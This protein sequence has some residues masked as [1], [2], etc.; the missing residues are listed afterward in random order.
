MTINSQD[1]QLLAALF[2]GQSPLPRSVKKSLRSKIAARAGVP[3]EELKA[4][5]R[6]AK[7]E[8]SALSGAFVWAIGGSID[9]SIG[10]HLRT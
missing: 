3:A 4:V 8:V 5:E 10:G 9:G 1:D 6:E 7:K 2:R